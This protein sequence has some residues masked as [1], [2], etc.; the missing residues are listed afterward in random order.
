MANA[1][2]LYETLDTVLANLHMW[3][4]DNYVEWKKYRKARTLGE[5]GTTACIAGFRCLMDGLLPV[6][7]NSLHFVDPSTGCVV[8]ASGYAERRFGLT[9]AEAYNLFYY[10]TDDPA[11]LKQ[12]VD[13]IIAGEWDY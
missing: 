1:E 11:K 8:D 12:R 6:R 13:E 2:A 5:C 4:Q 7:F 10:Y 3:D 9:P